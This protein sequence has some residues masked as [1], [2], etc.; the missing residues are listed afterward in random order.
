[1]NGSQS[2]QEFASLNS[3]LL[4]ETFLQKGI[5]HWRKLEIRKCTTK[6]EAQAD[7]L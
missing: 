1:M 4:F 3:L 6:A 7:T 2:L 5:S